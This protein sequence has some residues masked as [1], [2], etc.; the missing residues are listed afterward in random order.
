M[1]AQPVSLTGMRSP[2]HR[3]AALGG[4]LSYLRAG[5]EQGRDLVLIHGLGWDAERLWRHQ[6]AAV[7]RAGWR[8]FAPDMR[9][10]GYSAPLTGPVTIVDYAND[11]AGLI[12]DQRITRP[13]LVGFSMGCPIAA[14]LA[15]RLQIEARGLVLA[16]GGLRS[17]AL[18]AQATERMLIRATALGPTAFAAEQSIAIFGPAYAA[19]H[20]GAIADF[21]RWRAQMDQP[22]LHHAFRAGFGCDYEARLSEMP[23]PVSVIAA[24]LDSFVSVAAARAMAREARDATVHVIANSGHMAPV[25]QPAAFNAALLDCLAEVCA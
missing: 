17:S 4:R 12:A 3:S 18:G 8:V 9:G 6:I 25:E 14:D 19:A 15:L 11:V 5:P 16:C 1:T 24:D 21:V 7:A 13:V 2:T 22:G 10:V 23:C 20:P